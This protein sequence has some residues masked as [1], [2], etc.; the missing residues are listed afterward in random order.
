MRTGHRGTLLV[1]DPKQTLITGSDPRIPCGIP[2]PAP[3][4]GKIISD[5][6]LFALGCPNCQGKNTAREAVLFCNSY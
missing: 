6:S 4:A 5:K 3:I 2:S 1:A